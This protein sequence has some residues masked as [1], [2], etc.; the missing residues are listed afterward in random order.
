MLTRF[1]LLFFPQC[2]GNIVAVVDTVSIVPFP[3]PGNPPLAVTNITMLE[4]DSRKE[5][6]YL[7][8]KN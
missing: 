4:S 7:S 1:M 3:R 2:L 5:E 8:D 6:I